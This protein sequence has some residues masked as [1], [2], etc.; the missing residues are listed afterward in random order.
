MFNSGGGSASA[1]RL[2][3][4]FSV[5]FQELPVRIDLEARLFSI[6]SDDDLIVPSAIR[7]VFPFYLNDFSS[8]R[9]LINRLLDRSGERV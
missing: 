2:S 8:R 9:L 4:D 7:V 1:L 3:F 5:L 6:R